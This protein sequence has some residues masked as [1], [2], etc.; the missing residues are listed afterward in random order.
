MLKPTRRQFLNNSAGLLT[1]SALTTSAA[2]KSPLRIAIVGIGQ[3]GINHLSGCSAEQLVAVCDPDTNRLAVASEQVP[4]ALQYLDYRRMLD[5]CELD[6]IVISTPIHL[7]SHIATAADNLGIHCYI[8]KPLAYSIQQVRDLIA[9]DA[10]SKLNHQMGNQHHGKPGYREAGALLKSGLIG[11]IKECHA[12]TNRPIWVQGN[13]K[14]R[15]Q[16]P[17]KTLDF[18][19]WLGPSQ[20]V[21]FRRDLHPFQWRGWWQ[22]GCGALGDMGPHLLDTVF[23]G[24][25]L[26][27]PT[28]VRA[29]AKDA[30]THHFPKASVVEMDVTSPNADP[31]TI[32]WYDGGWDFPLDRIGVNR[33]PANG[34]MV[35][36]EHGR[37]FIPELGG[38]PQ[39]IPDSGANLSWRFITTVTEYDH[40]AHWIA[41]CKTGRKITNLA[42]G[43]ILTETCQRGNVALYTLR[44]VTDDVIAEYL[45]EP[46]RVPFV[47]STWRTKW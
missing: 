13:I 43:G 15:R 39:L 24:L 41:A 33:P 14:P 47:R 11:S 29:A 26:S 31:F 8:E 27:L 37:V 16:R 6:A 1:S 23:E 34:V 36:G 35:I 42:H 18:N 22:F 9:L 5:E 30:S 32:H 25:S 4:D 38:K 2:Q 40:L 45:E 19:L 3:H 46:D 44:E 17:P 21:A 7:H 10:R 28:R 20:P 12:W